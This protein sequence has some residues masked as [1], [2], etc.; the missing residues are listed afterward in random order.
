MRDKRTPK[1]VCGEARIWTTNVRFFMYFLLLNVAF[2]IFR[3]FEF[4]RDSYLFGDMSQEVSG[5]S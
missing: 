3:I 1:D 2:V 5:L 4:K